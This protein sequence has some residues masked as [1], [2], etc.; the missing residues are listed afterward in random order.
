MRPTDNVGTFRYT[1]GAVEEALELVAV[2]VV[3]ELV[4]GG[5]ARVAPAAVC[6]AT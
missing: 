3:V 5:V 4:I 1:S 6:A 2:G